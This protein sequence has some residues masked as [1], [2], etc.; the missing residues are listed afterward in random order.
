MYSRRKILYKCNIYLKLIGETDFIQITQNDDAEY[1]PVWSNDGNT[2]AYLRMGKEETGIFSRPLIG[3]REIKL[4][5]YPPLKSVLKNAN[6]WPEIDWSWDGEWL[7]F[8]DLDSSESIHC[9][10]RLNVINFEKEQLTFPESTCFGDMNARFSPDGESI[11]FKRVY[12]Y[13]MGDL[14]LLNLKTK[15]INQLTFDKKS[16]IGVAWIS[17]SNEIIFS[18]NRDGVYRLWLISLKNK[19]MQLYPYTVE[20]PTFLSVSRLGNRLAYSTL[21][22]ICDIYQAD[23]P[24]EK[25]G[26]IRPYKLIGS[27]RGEYFGNY[28]PDGKRIAFGSDRTGNDEIWTC[29]LDG[30]DEIQITNLKVHSNWPQWS[31]DGQWIVFENDGDIMISDAKGIN[32]PERLISDPSDDRNPSWSQDGNWVYF[33]SNRNGEFHVFKVH[34]KSGEVLQMTETIS[35]SGFESP[36]GKF[37]YFKPWKNGSIVKQLDLSTLKETVLIE[38]ANYISFRIAKSGMYYITWDQE[39]GNCL[40]KLYQFAAGSIEDLGII[41]TGPDIQ[42][43]FTD[44]TDDGSKIL[45]WNMDEASDIY[46]IDNFR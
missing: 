36:D 23:M 10:F 43:K 41:E 8:N 5:D 7:V 40:L 46:L 26:K 20:F 32:P 42:L 22:P 34:I 16:I 6:I 25:G 12:G 11:V 37:F 38:E 18:S 30:S 19:Q 3:G 39:T 44:V 1:C 13:K 2:F 4:Y 15:E 45:F 33:G 14:F 24:K 27:S 21:F 35:F 31:P 29:K 28:S 17:K 9:L